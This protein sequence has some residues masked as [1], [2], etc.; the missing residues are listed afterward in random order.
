MGVHR[1]QRADNALRLNVHFHTAGAE[2]AFVP[3][4]TNASANS[5]PA[6]MPGTSGE[7]ATSP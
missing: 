4:I 5:G 1:A 6:Q 2:L 3:K 7:R